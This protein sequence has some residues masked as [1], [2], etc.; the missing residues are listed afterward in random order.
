MKFSAATRDPKPEFDSRSRKWI[1]NFAP[2]PW[3]KVMYFEPIVFSKPRAKMSPW[4]DAVKDII[5]IDTSTAV[6]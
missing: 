4:N 6:C 5:K 2:N 1:W 3:P